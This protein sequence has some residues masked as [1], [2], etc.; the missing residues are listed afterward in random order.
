MQKLIFSIV[1]LL[2]LSLSTSVFAKDE[3]LKR[4][5]PIA[6]P[7]FLTAKDFGT[8][9][10]HKFFK[11][12]SNL[13]RSLPL[14]DVGVVIADNSKNLQDHF[15]NAKIP[16][17]LRFYCEN[18]TLAF[19]IF[20]LGSEIAESSD[21]LKGWVEV[22]LAPGAT[23]PKAITSSVYSVMGF[24]LGEVDPNYLYIGLA[25]GTP[26]T[27]SEEE[28]A[29]EDMMESVSKGSLGNMDWIQINTA[30][31]RKEAVMNVLPGNGKRGKKRTK[32]ELV[33][34]HGRDV[35][36]YAQFGMALEEL[37][38]TTVKRVLAE[39]TYKNFVKEVGTASKSALESLKRKQAEIDSQD[40]VNPDAA[41]ALAKEWAIYNTAITEAKT[42]AN[43][44]HFI[45]S[46]LQGAVTELERKVAEQG[47]QL[48]L[49]KSSSFKL[50]KLL[51]RS[52]DQALL[53]WKHA[54]F[55]LRHRA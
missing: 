34:W 12:R 27:T 25:P 4:A 18:D 40:P 30:N 50:P 6:Y 44:L 52:N 35:L 20:E 17:H 1:S 39:K 51:K 55:R 24:L 48:G 54:E 15:T 2:C 9:I 11:E 45:I 19:R 29:R 31:P 7:H 37:A 32:L 36:A 22:S 46:T 5:L 38:G 13:P 10:D 21:T 42:Q 16:S 26:S 23:V 8:E 47:E 3:V 28:D 43:L 33:C 49:W 41:A 14:K 53:N